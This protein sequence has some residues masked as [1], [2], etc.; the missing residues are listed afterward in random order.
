MPQIYHAHAV[1]NRVIVAICPRQTCSDAGV[2]YQEPRPK[3]MPSDPVPTSS[4]RTLNLADALN[5]AAALIREG[6]LDG[7]ERLCL[8]ILKVMPNDFDAVFLLGMVKAR[9]GDHDAALACFDRAL[10]SN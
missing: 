4:T 7:A 3:H 10:Q 6:K 8:D 5:H 1:R 2:A 9:R